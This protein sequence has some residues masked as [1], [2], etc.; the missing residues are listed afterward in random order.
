MMLCG[1]GVEYYLLKP[2]D[3]NELT[4]ALEKIIQKR[5]FVM[6]KEFEDEQLKELAST[7]R[8]R[9]KEHFLTEYH[10]DNIHDGMELEQINEEYQCKFRN[11]IFRATFFKID[12]VGGDDSEIREMLRLVNDIIEVGPYAPSH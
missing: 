2:I 9:M 6:Q 3:K 11:G 7:S 8:K 10:N 4:S 5:H 1:L 12:S